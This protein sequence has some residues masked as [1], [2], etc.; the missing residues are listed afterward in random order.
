MGI[1]LRGKD[2]DEASEQNTIY[3]ELYQAISNSELNHT[4]RKKFDASKKT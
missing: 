2:R 3:I 4:I 1:Q